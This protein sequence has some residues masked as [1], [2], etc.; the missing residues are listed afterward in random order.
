MLTD[1]R[2]HGL[3][4]DGRKVI[5]IAHPEQSSGELKAKVDLPGKESANRQR[6]KDNSSKE[7]VPVRPSASTQSD[8]FDAVIDFKD[9]VYTC[10]VCDLTIKQKRNVKPHLKSS[11]HQKNAK[12]R[13]CVNYERV[14]GTGSLLE[15]TFTRPS[16]SLISK[17]GSHFW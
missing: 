6:V 8:S 10:I 7:S 16:D 4:D 2:T 12:I 1:G 9:G 3:A 14:S 11:R 5:T 17:A 15:L 13:V